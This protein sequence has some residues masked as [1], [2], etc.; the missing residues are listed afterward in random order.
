MMENFRNLAM[1][2][3]LASPSVG[4]ENAIA[5]YRD[6]C[7]S[8]LLMVGSPAGIPASYLRPNRFYIQPANHNNIQRFQRLMIAGLPGKWSQITPIEKVSQR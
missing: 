8:A 3:W 2:Q 6:K 4:L 7:L 5:G 1:V